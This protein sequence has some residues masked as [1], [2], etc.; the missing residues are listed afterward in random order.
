MPMTGAMMKTTHEMPFAIESSVS[1][2]KSEAWAGEGSARAAHAAISQA[3]RPRRYLLFLRAGGASVFPCFDLRRRLLV[4]LIRGVAGQV[5]R[6]VACDAGSWF[7][8]PK[9]LCPAKS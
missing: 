5:A 2:W 3:Q 4:R 6:R 1:P 8:V 7:R 9:R